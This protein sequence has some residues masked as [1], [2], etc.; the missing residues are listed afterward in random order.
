MTAVESGFRESRITWASSELLEASDLTF[1]T[2]F[3]F[4]LSSQVLLISYGRIVHEH[5]AQQEP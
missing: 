3:A 1:C 5:M 2:A 4:F